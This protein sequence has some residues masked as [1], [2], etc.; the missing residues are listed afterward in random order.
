M[1]PLKR[2]IDPENGMHNKCMFDYDQLISRLKGKSVSTDV[3]VNSLNNGKVLNNRKN[4]F[5]YNWRQKNCA[6]DSE[7]RYEVTGMP[8]NMNQKLDMYQLQLV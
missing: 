7:E 5:S 4:Y 3:S 8:Q 1:G 2:R 6:V